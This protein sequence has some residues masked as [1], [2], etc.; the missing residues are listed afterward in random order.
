M[1][2]R[3][4]AHIHLFRPGYTSHLPESCA[5]AQPD[6]VTLYEAL[7]AE[8]S[9]EQALVVGYEGAPRFAGNNAYLS[10]LAQQHRWIKPVAYVDP[11]ALSCTKLEQ[12][13]RDGFVGI[14]LYIFSPQSIAALA[15][16]PT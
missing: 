9:I 3:A 11:E 8:F 13:H 2:A 6:E 1:A 7:A 5:R 10:S 4:D 16:V 15:A 14:S 12:L